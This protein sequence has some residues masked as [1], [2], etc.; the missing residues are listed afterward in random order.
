MARC[1]P[2]CRRVQLD[3]SAVLTGRTYIGHE[4]HWVAVTLHNLELRSVGAARPTPWGGG[5]VI[6][7]QLPLM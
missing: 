2:L 5:G 4:S 1:G 3:G 7:L 6:L